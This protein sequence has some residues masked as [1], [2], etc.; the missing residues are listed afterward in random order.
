MG[1]GRWSMSVELSTIVNQLGRSHRSHRTSIIGPGAS[2]TALEH[3]QILESPTRIENHDRIGGGNVASSDEL[4]ERAQR[5]AAFG[6]RA[7]AFLRPE[8]PHV[9]DHV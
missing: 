1:D 6:C 9:G 4:L 7:D 3:I 5:R 8:L 2:P